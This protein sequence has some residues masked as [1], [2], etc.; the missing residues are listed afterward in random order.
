MKIGEGAGFKIGEGAGF[1]SLRARTENFVEMFLDELH[2]ASKTGVTLS[3]NRPIKNETNPIIDAD[4][5]DNWDQM[6]AFVYWNM[7]EEPDGS[8]SAYYSA[9]DDHGVINPAK[10]VSADI[11]TWTKPNLGLITYEGNTNNNLIGANAFGQTVHYYPDQIEAQRYIAVWHEAIAPSRNWLMKASDGTNFTILKQMISAADAP[12]GWFEMRDVIQRASDGLWI[13]YGITGHLQQ[14]RQVA[15][16]VSSTDAPDSTYNWVSGYTNGIVLPST[17]ETNQKYHSS[18]IY[19]GHGVY[20]HQVSRFVRTGADACGKNSGP[21]PSI[22]LYI[23]RDCL[24]FSLLDADWIVRGDELEWDDMMVLPTSSI[25]RFG[26]TW[27]IFY[28]ASGEDHNNC[29]W[30]TH[31][32]GYSTIPFRRIGQISSNGTLTTD[33]I[34][35]D[36]VMTINCNAASGSIDIELLDPSDNSVLTGYAQIDCDTISVNEFD[37]IVTWGG[38]SVLPIGNFKIKFYLTD[39]NLHSYAICTWQ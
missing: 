16:L 24:D 5:I 15:A 14:R 29:V 38:S 34:T 12:L 22:E 33:E 6:Y 37:K 19:L 17:E 36:D 23:S 32:V 11:E 7:L 8:Y 27:R 1:N 25:I 2:I 30:K 20:L 39:A 4:Q 13:V 35:T 10:M 28:G 26:N 31:F 18:S 9:K 21:F 3:I